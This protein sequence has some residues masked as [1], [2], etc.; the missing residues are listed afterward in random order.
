M[1]H[2]LR[3]LPPVKLVA[4]YKL[5]G[6]SSSCSHSLAAGLASHSWSAVSQ[7]SFSRRPQARPRRQQR[8][9]RREARRRRVR[10]RNPRLKHRHCGA[11]GLWAIP[12]R[13]GLGRGQLLHQ[14]DPS[15]P[16][17]QLSHPTP[18]RRLARHQREGLPASRGGGKRWES[19]DQSVTKTRV[20]AAPLPALKFAGL[21]SGRGEFAISAIVTCRLISCT[22]TT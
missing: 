20:G 18:Q 9:D 12:F 2:S 4:R 7:M 5:S 11:A 19:T 1:R 13:G 10:G 6:P 8:P 16:L 14:S 3:R 17:R 15:G 21:G 22:A